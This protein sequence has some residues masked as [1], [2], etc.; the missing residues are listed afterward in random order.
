MKIKMELETERLILRPWRI[1]D[2]PA[3]YKYASDPKVGPIAGWPVHTSI[4]N[5]RE[6]IREVFS[7]E[8]IYAIV[9]KGQEEPVGCI[10]LLIGEASDFGIGPDEGEIAYWIGV[11]YWGKGLVPEA[12]RELMRY[13]F[14]ELELKTLWCGYFEGNEKSIRAQEKCGFKYHHTNHEK[15]WP[16][17]GDVRTEIITCITKEQWLNNISPCE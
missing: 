1:E 8:G 9:P 16:L 17:M 6:T 2:A 14:E 15:F 13:C 3:L 4:E 10:G 12:I 5:S 11:P 7:N